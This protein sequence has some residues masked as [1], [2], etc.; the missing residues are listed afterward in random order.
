MLR[1]PAGAQSSGTFVVDMGNNDMANTDYSDRWQPLANGINESSGLVQATTV[2]VGT[3]PSRYN[4][5]VNQT[6]TTHLRLGF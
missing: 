1:V 4:I 2:I 5:T 6:F 3:T